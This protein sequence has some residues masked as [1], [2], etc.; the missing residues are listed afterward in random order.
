MQGWL[1]SFLQPE[2]WEGGDVELGDELE[3]LNFRNGEVESHRPGPLQGSGVERP[4][5]AQ[6]VTPGSWGRV[7]YRAPRREPASPSACVS[8]YE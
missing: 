8:A 6:G 3:G 1:W 5:L 2:D 4:P 7:P